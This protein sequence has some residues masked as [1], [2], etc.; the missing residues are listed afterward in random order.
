MGPEKNLPHS[1]KY[2]GFW[3]GFHHYSKRVY[4]PRLSY[5][6]AKYRTENVESGDHLWMLENGWTE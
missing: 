4:T 5:E 3:D 1:W 6:C 2:S